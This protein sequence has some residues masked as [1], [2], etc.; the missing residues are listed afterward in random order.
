[1]IEPTAARASCSGWPPGSTPRPKAPPAH[2]TA[3]GVL[4][5]G[6]AHRGTRC[7]G[8]AVG[9]Q[10]RRTHTDKHQPSPQ[11][12]ALGCHTLRHE[13][14]APHQ[15]CEELQGPKN[16]SGA[17]LSPQFGGWELL[18]PKQNVTEYNL[19]HTGNVTDRNT[20]RGGVPRCS[21]VLSEHEV[22]RGW[23]RGTPTRAPPRLLRDSA[24]DPE[25]PVPPRRLAG[26]AS[27]TERQKRVTRH[28]RSCWCQEP[29]TGPRAGQRAEGTLRLWPPPSGGGVPTRVRAELL[30]LPHQKG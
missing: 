1:M 19:M 9:K 23:A 25:R 29:G 27:L 8:Q 7:T 22:A 13:A 26:P 5:A 18:R 14:P 6:S 2:T 12:R 20:G 21:E 16:T 10:F 11:A 17:G 3:Q 28:V 4:Q 15:A 30:G 24:G